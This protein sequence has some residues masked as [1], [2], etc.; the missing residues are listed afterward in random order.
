MCVG[1]EEEEE[2]GDFVFFLRW[3][4]VMG[5]RKKWEEG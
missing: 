2:G 4:D 3:V 5:E 1:G